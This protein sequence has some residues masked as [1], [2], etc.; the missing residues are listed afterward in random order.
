MLFPAG[1]SSWYPPQSQARPLQVA[2]L[3]SSCSKC[4]W[5]S[6]DVPER[7]EQHESPPMQTELSC[8][9]C[10]ELQALAANSEDRSCPAWAAQGR[11]SS[12]QATCD[13]A[14]LQIAAMD[15]EGLKTSLRHH[16]Y[17]ARNEHAALHLVELHQ[18]ASA[19]APQTASRYDQ[20]KMHSY[21]PNS[22]FIFAC[23]YRFFLS[24]GHL[25]ETLR[26]ELRY[27]ATA[28]ALA[29]PLDAIAA[30]S[31]HVQAL[32]AGGRLGS[33]CRGPAQTDKMAGCHTSCP[34]PSPHQ[35]HRRRLR[36]P[37]APFM[38]GRQPSGLAR[39]STHS[40]WMRRSAAQKQ[41]RSPPGTP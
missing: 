15:W 33:H 36:Y 6:A 14:A 13:Q 37:G 8:L 35:P 38:Q 30:T 29:Q 21:C 23:D 26:N 11:A 34:P 22:L 1:H 28:G 17:N 40:S 32:W 9:P 39:C 25:T 4:I 24:K 3:M 19:N 12:L 20:G 27:W 18:T 16:Q 41:P 5:W 2:I 10:L 31:E 7:V